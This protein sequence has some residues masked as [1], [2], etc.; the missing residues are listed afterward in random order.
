MDPAHYLNEN[1]HEHF[2]SQYVDQSIF[3]CLSS[4]D[5][6]L[7]SFVE[8]PTKDMRG[9]PLGHLDPSKMEHAFRSW[10]SINGPLIFD[11]LWIA[12]ESLFVPPPELKVRKNKKGRYAALYALDPKLP[13]RRNPNDCPKTEYIPDMD[14][15]HIIMICIHALTSLVTKGRPQTWDEIRNL[16][17]KGMMLPNTSSRE[18]PNDAY[19]M[20]WLD[21]IDQ[22]EY[23]PA[24]RLADRLARAVAARRCFAEIQQTTAK[25]DSTIPFGPAMDIVIEH[26]VH[27]ERQRQKASSADGD[28]LKW[29]RETWGSW[30]VSGVFIEWL[31]T[32]IMKHWKGQLEL[33][34]WDTVGAAAEVLADMYRFHTELG[35][36]KRFFHVQHLR[37]KVDTLELTTSYMDRKEDPNTFHLLQYPFLFQDHVLVYYF[38]TFSYSSMSKWYTTSGNNWSLQDRFSRHFLSNSWRNYLNE[39]YAV[40]S[41]RYLKLD[42]RRSNVLEDTLDQLW[43]LEKRQLLLPLKVRIG[44]DEGERGVDQ[45]GVAQEFFRAALAEAFNPDNGMFT[46]DP[47]NRMTWFQPFSLE[48]L[49][50]FE[51]IGLLFSI[52]VYN[53]ITLP[54]TLPKAFYRRLLGKPV[55]NVDQI[56]DGWPDLA[57]SFDF[58]LSCEDEVGDILSREYEFS[59]EARGLVININMADLDHE[60]PSPYTILDYTDTDDPFA[61][62][63]NWPPE[64]SEAPLVTNANRHQYVRDYISWLV[65]KSIKPQFDAFAR[66]FRTCLPAKHLALLRPSLLR[67]TVEGSMHIDTHA[68][69]RVTR[70]DGGF[71]AEHA[72]V[73]EF[74][75]V[76]HAWDQE[77]KRK[78]LEFVTASDRVPVAGI[79]SVVFWVQRNGPDGEGLPTSSTCF[80]RLLLPEYK[81]REKLEQKLG[82]AIENARGFGAA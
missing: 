26:L 49:S 37:E 60:T 14:A 51:L 3:H 76:V 48:P 1:A 41:S 81:D 62:V 56:R 54:V 71:S 61:L 9:S 47:Q 63:V 77:R 19:S 66:G 29:K 6:L 82:V 67:R 79:E 55:I 28:N 59:F 39:H 45:G 70:Y 30:S 57:R 78:L 31:R 80:G 72:F 68:L 8:K 15:A 53:G 50:R 69:E 73:R 25:H 20:P 75:A 33:K 52:A 5:I 36:R 10:Q 7:R 38:R 17:I 18:R 32:L 58:L 11:S 40:A 44:V 23:E 43:G 22:L 27:V 21:T 46:V 2:S 65:D 24:V 74:W 16:R 13:G 64:P 4:P 42:V 34:R 12:L 35:L